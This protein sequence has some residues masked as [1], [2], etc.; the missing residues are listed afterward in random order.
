VGKATFA[1]LVPSEASSM[2]N[3]RLASAHLTGGARRR[4]GNAAGMEESGM[5]LSLAAR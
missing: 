1:L 3:E 2:V 5:R 4:P